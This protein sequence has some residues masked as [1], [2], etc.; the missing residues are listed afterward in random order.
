MKRVFITAVVVS[1]TACSTF[2]ELQLPQSSG[3]KLSG[4]TYIP[5]DPL[6]V[7]LPLCE[8]KG[9]A[10]KPLLDALPDNTIRMVV[11]EFDADGSLSF[12]LV[13]IGVQGKRY[14][15][16]LDYINSDITNIWVTVRKKEGRISIERLDKAFSPD[17]NN[18]DDSLVYSGGIPV[19]IGVGLRLTADFKINHGEV[20]LSSLGSI[21]AAVEAGNATGSLV[22]QTLGMTG[23]QVSTVLPLPSELNQT[24][25]QNAILALGSIK[26]MLNSEKSLV[27]TPRV[28]GMYIPFQADLATINVIIT[29]LGGRRIEWSQPCEKSIR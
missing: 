19:Y 17:S 26:T 22:V 10:L 18:K 7:A 12:G 11:K 1:L 14:Q 20:R 24:T 6:P 21:A 13:N 2:S 9:F 28:V 23:K 29:T 3:E 25:V 27:I 4:Y 15:V 16:V 5:L 8:E